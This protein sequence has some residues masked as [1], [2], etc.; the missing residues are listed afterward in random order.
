[1]QEPIAN[2]FHVFAAE[3]E[4]TAA[5]F[6]VDNNLYF[7]ATPKAI[8]KAGTWVFDHPFFIIL[9]IA[10]GGDWPGA[11]DGTTQFPQDMIVDY[12]RVYQRAK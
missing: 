9:N 1:M 8:S 3:W 4:Q 11:P 5:R 2:A 7:T 10:L 6:Y 12:V